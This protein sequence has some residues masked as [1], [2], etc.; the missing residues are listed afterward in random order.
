[1]TKEC[2]VAQCVGFLLA[3]FE[4]VQ[5]T[6]SCIS[7]DLATN[8][9]AQ[10]KLIEEV[11]ECFAKAGGLDYSSVQEIPYLDCVI[12]GKTNLTF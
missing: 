6:L 11:Q 8:P 10:D 1:M 12:K 3:G 4:T 7:W 2:M 5:N 9:E